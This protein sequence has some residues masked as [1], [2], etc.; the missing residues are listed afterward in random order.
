MKA[1]VRARGYREGDEEEIVQL[2]DRILGWPAFD[3]PVSKIDHW[4]W[5]YAE[6]PIGYKLI[7]LVK[8]DR[9]VICHSAG[10]PMRIKVGRGTYLCTDGVDVCWDP[11]RAR[12][13]RIFDAINEKQKLKA[14][15][16]IDFDYVFPVEDMRD[17]LMKEFGYVDLGLPLHSYLRVLDPGK[18]FEENAEGVLKRSAYRAYVTTQN[19]L[20][21][22]RRRSAKGIGLREADSIGPEMTDLFV[23]ASEAFD[24]I[25]VRD[26]EHLNWRYRDERAGRFRILIAEKEGKAIGYA[27]L[28][29]EG[30]GGHGICCIADMLVLPG[31]PNVAASLVK[32]AVSFAEENDAISI[33]CGIL[34]GHPYIRALEGAGFVRSR[35][36]HKIREPTLAV[37]NR[38]GLPEIG[39]MLSKKRMRI[40]MMLGDTDSV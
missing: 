8:D 25:V 14:K 37:S 17:A 10:V 33:Y 22:S 27:V 29:F 39:A 1:S 38:N 35:W 26:Q 3:I 11:A 31:R 9:G 34:K 36:R 24:I 15:Y 12:P 18:F 23:K 13:E 7:G 20:H 2:L 6:N 40:H 30:K 32:G 16:P 21:A 5:K 28:K 4:R 19:G